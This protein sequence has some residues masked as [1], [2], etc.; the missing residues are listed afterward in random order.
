[1]N[2]QNNDNYYNYFASDVAA[3]HSDHFVNIFDY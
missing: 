3:V 2:K 1:M